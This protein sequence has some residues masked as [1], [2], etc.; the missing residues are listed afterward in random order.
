MC[1]FCAA[2]S[3]GRRGCS[4][5]PPAIR[6]IFFGNSRDEPSS[7]SMFLCD[8]LGFSAARQK[9]GVKLWGHPVLLSEI[10]RLLTRI[11]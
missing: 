3:A 11:M 5:Y 9:L 6:R 2:G 10:R 8:E 1:Q 7:T 4:G